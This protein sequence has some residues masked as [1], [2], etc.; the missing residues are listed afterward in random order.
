MHS[1]KDAFKLWS[2][3]PE[4]TD[5]LV[6]H[7]PPFGILDQNYNKEHVGCESLTEHVL[8]IKPQLHIFGHIHEDYG[9]K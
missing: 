4:D 8:R 1:K 5:V 2:A 6:T 9:V 3:I 7:G